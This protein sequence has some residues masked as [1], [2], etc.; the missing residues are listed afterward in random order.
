[1]FWMG[2]PIFKFLC[3]NFLKFWVFFLTE[4]FIQDREGGISKWGLLPIG[5]AL[6]YLHSI[7]RDRACEGRSAEG[8]RGMGRVDAEWM[9][10]WPTVAGSWAWRI[11]RLPFVR[12]LY[13]WSEPGNSPVP[14]LV[15]ISGRPCPWTPCILHPRSQFGKASRNLHNFPKRR[16]GDERFISVKMLPLQR[17]GKAHSVSDLQMAFVGTVTGKKGVSLGALSLSVPCWNATCC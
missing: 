2:C 8:G 4:I 6:N 14:P 16:R 12:C 11:V 10:G 5:S 7:Y 13:Q 1:M 3:K 15:Q 17:V 9:F